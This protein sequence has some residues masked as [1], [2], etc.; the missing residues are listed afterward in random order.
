MGTRTQPRWYQAGRVQDSAPDRPIHRRVFISVVVGLVRVAIY[1]VLIAPVFVFSA[2]GGQWLGKVVWPGL[3][4][5]FHG[6]SWIAG[7]LLITWLVRVKVNK[8]SWSGM[9][10]P[11]PQWL[12]LLLGTLAGF[13]VIMLASGIEYQLG[14]LHLARIDTSPHRGLSKT[15]W[16]ALALSPSLAVGF[17]EELAFRGYIFQT[18]GERMPV[19]AAGLL[20]SVLFAVLH[21]SLSGFNAAFVVSV[22][23]V[24][25]M[26]LA[27]RFATGSLWFP[28][29]FHGAWDWTQTYFVGLATTGTQGYDSA[30]IQVR[31]TGPTF[32][33][34][35]QQAIESGLLFILI[36]LGLL[37]LALVY[38]SAS[39][40]PRSWTKRLA[41]ETSH[42]R[43]ASAS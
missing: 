27:L 29:G 40:K 35:Y 24:S 13:A 25:L 1:I 34:G 22:I 21:F 37:V 30:L 14:W 38:V 19:W 43:P 18:L 2:L 17:A 42:P 6:I 31:Q 39:S 20:M 7:V 32:W 41:E 11:R 9:A 16:I 5:L 36:A 23:V 28:I 26:F 15:L 3:S 10:L 12:R 8:A 33:V 4:P